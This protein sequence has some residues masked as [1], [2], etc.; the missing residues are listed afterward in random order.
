MDGLTYKGYKFKLGSSKMKL[1][2]TTLFHPLHISLKISLITWPYT[3]SCLGH[4][5]LSASVHSMDCLEG[6]IERDMYSVAHLK[7]RYE[8]VSCVRFLLWCQNWKAWRMNESG[9]SREKRTV[10]WEGQVAVA[11]GSH[12]SL[13]PAWFL[14]SVGRVLQCL[15]TSCSWC[16][17]WLKLFCV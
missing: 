4:L 11:V 16:P 15:L 12:L 9:N 1:T 14:Y 5:S 10:S 2:S 13:S 17:R 7:Q 3:S 6:Q 8:T